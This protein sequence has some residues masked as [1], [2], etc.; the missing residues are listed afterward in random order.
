MLLLLDYCLCA[1]IV[2]TSAVYRTAAPDGVYFTIIEAHI[3]NIVYYFI[4]AVNAQNK[5]VSSGF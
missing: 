4:A 3:R 2:R 1:Q 5:I